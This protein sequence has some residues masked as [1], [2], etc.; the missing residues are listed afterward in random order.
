MRIRKEVLELALEIARESYPREFVALLTGKRGV[1][2]ELTFL[3]FESSESSAI[4]HYEMLPLGYKIYGTIHSHPTPSCKP[5]QADLE[6]FSKRGSIHIIVC[7]PF[8]WGC[9]KFYDRSGNEIHLE[10]LD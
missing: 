5:S 1:I 9:W 2:E 3:P 7:Y 4:I 10:I 8:E 6:M